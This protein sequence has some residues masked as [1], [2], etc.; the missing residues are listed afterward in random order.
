MKI[1]I[2]Q[3]NPVIGDISGNAKL[4]LDAAQKAKKL[5]AKLMITPELSLIGYPPRDLLIYP[6]LIE[7]AVLELENLAKYLPSEIAVLVGTVTF[8]YQAANTGEKSLF[9]SAVLLTNGEIKQVFHKQLLPTYDVFDE[10][11]YFEPGKTRDFFTLENYSNSSE[12]LAK[13]GV[14]ICEDLWNDEAFWGKRNY[15]YDPMK[16]LAAQKVDFVINMSASPYQTGKQKLREAMLKH[17]TN[18]YQIPIIYVNQVGGN[19]DLIFDGCSV[20]FNGAGNVVYRAQ[21]FETSLAVVE[22]NSAKKDFISVDFKSINLPESEDEE[23][24]SALVL[25]L[26]DYVQKCGFS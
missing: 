18:C 11:R 12:N 26:R 4:I 17:S 5:D 23:I 21:A 10:D 8:N 25:G 14:T 16:E 9:N 7:A 13:V 2:A 20:V 1:A 3:L 15:A 19:D 22:F 6:S 24:W